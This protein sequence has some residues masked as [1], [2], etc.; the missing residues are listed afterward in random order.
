M[1]SPKLPGSKQ[2]SIFQASAP[3]SAEKLLKYPDWLQIVYSGPS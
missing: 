3:A 1:S 2:P